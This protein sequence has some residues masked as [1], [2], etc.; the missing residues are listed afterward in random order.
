M[1]PDKTDIFLYQE[2][3]SG[4]TVPLVKTYVRNRLNSPISNFPLYKASRKYYL[5]L[6]TL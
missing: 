3:T 4:R 5:L 1:N 2:R 6:L